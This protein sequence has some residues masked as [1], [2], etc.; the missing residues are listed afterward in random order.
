MELVK[1]IKFEAKSL[2]TSYAEIEKASKEIKMI[3]MRKLDA[4]K[5]NQNWGCNEKKQI[6]A[7]LESQRTALSKLSERITSFSKTCSNTANAFAEA[8][9]NFEK[10]R[11][12]IIKQYKESKNPL[13]KFWNDLVEK[14]KSARDKFWE[15]L[16][17]KKP[18][19]PT[20]GGNPFLIGVGLYT[21]IIAR[22]E[23]MALLAEAYKLDA[24]IEKMKADIL[25]CLLRGMSDSEAKKYGKTIKEGIDEM[26]GKNI[27]GTGG[28]NSNVT[29]STN[30]DALHTQAQNAELKDLIKKKQEAVNGGIS[31]KFEIISEPSKYKNETATQN[32]NKDHPFNCYCEWH[33]GH[34]GI[35]LYNEG[36][37][38]DKNGLTKAQPATT[39]VSGVVIDKYS[40]YKSDASSRGAPLGNYV[41]IKGVDGRIYTYAHLGEVNVSKGQ[42]VSSG[43]KIGLVGDTGYSDGAH[44]HFSVKENGKLVDPLEKN[45]AMKK[46]GKS[47]CDI[48]SAKNTKNCPKS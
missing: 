19:D 2:Y 17:G 10:A 22:M 20:K 3:A 37:K 46:N 31:N 34:S 26:V 38:K 40:E 7:S 30:A 23:R 12:A 18:N 35:D 11:K 21:T 39:I 45:Q 15:W 41:V 14:Y 28:L 32:I 44:L 13:L 48:C 6:E 24:E 42:F 29:G 47:V 25:K 43:L 1:T 9:E 36:A 4:A 27:M 5:N 8:E 16:T 33:T